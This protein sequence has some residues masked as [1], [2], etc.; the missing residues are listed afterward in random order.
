MKP[1]ALLW[2]DG[3]KYEG[4][5]VMVPVVEEDGEHDMTSMST[6][7]PVGVAR[8]EQEMS[9]AGDVATHVKSSNKITDR[10]VQKAKSRPEVI[11]RAEGTKEAVAKVIFPP[12]N[13]SQT[14]TIPN[15]KAVAELK[16]PVTPAKTEATPTT[17]ILKSGQD[18]PVPKSEQK[19][20]PKISDTPSRPVQTAKPAPVAKVP[21]APF[22]KVPVAP[23]T[24]VQVAPVAKAPVA[25]VALV[26]VA[27][28]AKVQVAPVSKV[29]V[30][31][32]AKVQVVP[33]AKVQVP[34]AAEVQ[35]AP[36]AKQPTREAPPVPNTI[37]KATT[38][39]IAV[40]TP[41]SKEGSPKSDKSN[42]CS[43][44]VP[45]SPSPVAQ[46]SSPRISAS[47]QTVLQYIPSVTSTTLPTQAPPTQLTQIVLPVDDI[48]S[49]GQFG[50]RLVEQ[51]DRLNSLLEKMILSPPKAVQD[52]KVGR[53]ET[54]AVVDE[55]I[56]YRGLAIKK[57]GE[58][59]QVYLLDY[60]GLL[61]V[62]PDQM[63]PL[64]ADCAV[65]P[66]ANFQV[67]LAGLGPR[68]GLE[69]G[70][71]EGK[72]LGEILNSS[73]EYRLGVEFVGQVDGGRWTVRLKGMED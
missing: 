25:P 44:G 32:A 61:T 1:P 71:E 16:L 49:P 41:G 8:L 54:V 20:N 15:T 29:Q 70:E 50:V 35:A 68:T 9:G 27:P 3:S 12:V 19:A 33:A 7:V 48:T 23:V 40:P 6:L 43:T 5:K 46:A 66:A 47:L 28:V 2:P 56:W 72:L 65:L 31:P 26:A 53:K 57:M 63:R 34:P 36:A 45:K 55:D 11:T 42:S 58:Q 67:C 10:E 59:F 69:W 60:G 38:K 18:V 22:A 52:W 4:E 13:S 39:Q 73:I 30:A 24:K 37:E 51:E 17:S 64:S 21:V 62:A 14:K